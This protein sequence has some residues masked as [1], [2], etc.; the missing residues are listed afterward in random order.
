M[1]MNIMLLF[2]FFFFA[3]YVLWHVDIFLGNDHEMSVSTTMMLGNGSS[4]KYK[5]NNA[6]ATWG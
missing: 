1:C 4:D 2:F 5:G 6:T 3:L